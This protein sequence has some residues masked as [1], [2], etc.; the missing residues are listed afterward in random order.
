MS[1]HDPNEVEESVDQLDDHPLTMSWRNA[2]SSLT[3][4]VR[5]DDIPRAVNFVIHMYE[6][7]RGVF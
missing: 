5:I 4:I 3:K 1:V 6:V 7:L 2:P